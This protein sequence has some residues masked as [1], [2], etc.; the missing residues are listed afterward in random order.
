MHTKKKKTAK[1]TKTRKVNESDDWFA[2][3]VTFP[4]RQRHDCMCGGLICILLVCLFVNNV[5]W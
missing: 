1:I 3:A 4:F 2:V 5:I